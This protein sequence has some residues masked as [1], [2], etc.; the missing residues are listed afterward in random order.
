MTLSQIQ[1][2]KNKITENFM[3]TLRNNFKRYKNVKVS[4]LKSAGHSREKVKEYKEEILDKLGG[5]YTAKII[6]FTIF[7]KKWRK[8]VR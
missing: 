1:L 4:I 8:G 3:E 7:I 2:G 5:N 6:G